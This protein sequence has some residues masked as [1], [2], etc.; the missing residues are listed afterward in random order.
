MNI[1]RAI[2]S[3]GYRLLE[4]LCIRI[5]SLLPLQNKVVASTFKGK[6]YGDNP[7]YILEKLHQMH[8][9]IICCWLKESDDYVLPDW[10]SGILL[11]NHF[12][13]IYHVSTAKVIIDT[14][15]FPLWMKKRK[16]Q[17]FVETWHGG[18]GIKKLEAD[19][20]RF[21]KLNFLMDEVRHTS[22]IADVFISQSDHLSQIYRR[23]FGYKGIIFKCGYPK[24]DKL[25][26]D[27]SL[28]RMSVRKYYNLNEKQNVFLYAPTF[29]DSFYEEINTS[30]YDV[31]FES[32]Q[33]S[34]KER[35]GG[36]WTIL[37]R[38][39]PLFASLLKN[40]SITFPT[41]VSDATDYSDMQ[42]LLKGCDG[43]LSDYSSCLFDAAMLDI[44]CF[45]FATDFDVYKADRGVYYEMEELPF[46]YARNNKEL[47]DNIS[48]YDHNVYLERWYA[49]KKQMGLYE[50]GNASEVIAEKII[51]FVRTGINKWEEELI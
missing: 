45:T 39:H 28:S 48:S 14:H 37:V 2:K 29:R 40:Q 22:D 19:V 26:Q 5:C 4:F 51:E 31:D 21:R 10:I 33:F 15:R 25:F 47:M 16:G 20:P 18:L 17:L 3:R 27:R 24:N 9:S 12:R 11:K 8:P 23:A 7:Q 34:L 35:F 49:F 30:V 44:P 1:I 43:V 50:P 36:E 42:E 32:L 41:C 46:S 6:K 38:W 13:A